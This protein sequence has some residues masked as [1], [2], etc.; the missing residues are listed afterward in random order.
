MEISLEIISRIIYENFGFCF[1]DG[2]FA[3]LLHLIINLKF[4]LF[5]RFEHVLK[6]WDES[7]GNH[8]ALILVKQTVIFL[9]NTYQIH[10]F[11]HYLQYT[12]N[13]VKHF[14]L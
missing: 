3:L 14:F 2:R 10:I 4:L 7:S 1:L 6:K 9:N 13:F 11:I 5:L 8:G 12:I